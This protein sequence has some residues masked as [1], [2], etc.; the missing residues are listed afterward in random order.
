[1]DHDHDRKAELL[2]RQS[3]FSALDEQQLEDLVQSAKRIR[4]G[5]GETIIRQGERG[6]SMFILAG[7]IAEVFVLK[8][9]TPLRVGVVRAGENFGEVSLLTGEPRSA[10]V[11]A[12]TDCEIFEID[13][14]AMAALFH[15]HPQFAEQLSETLAARRLA[16]KSE[17]ER[18]EIGA[19]ESTAGQTKENVLARLRLFF[20]L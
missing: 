4:F 18:L 19:A 14:P 2:R 16:T 5:K 11:T 10:T 8:G 13:K 20:Q 17:L 1:L 12:Q 6:D 3:L 7:G 9:G 15:E